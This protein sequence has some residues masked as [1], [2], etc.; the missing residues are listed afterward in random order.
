[1]T[2]K[3]KGFIIYQVSYIRNRKP[4]KVSKLPGLISAMFLSLIHAYL[5]K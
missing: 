4:W 5:P 3:V 2:T 1:M